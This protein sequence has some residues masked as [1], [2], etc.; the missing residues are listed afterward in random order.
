MINIKVT[1][2]ENL[3]VVWQTLLLETSI[4]FHIY[5]PQLHINTAGIILRFTGQVFY[6]LRVPVLKTRNWAE[7]FTCIKKILSKEF[8]VTYDISMNFHSYD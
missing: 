6:S 1:P 2:H 8:Q 5:V 3:P 4:K 7:T